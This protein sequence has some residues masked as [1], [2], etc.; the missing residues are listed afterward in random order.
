[1]QLITCAIVRSDLGSRPYIHFAN[2][3]PVTGIMI[4]QTS[5][6][7]KHF[8][9]VWLIVD[10]HH[11]FARQATWVIGKSRILADAMHHVDTKTIDTTIQPESQHL[12]H[13][14]HNLRVVPVQIRL[15]R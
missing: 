12:V 4:D 5:Q 8:M 14:F 13:R 7:A 2:Q 15:L 11:R 9:A 10:F 1:M 3:Y 6:A